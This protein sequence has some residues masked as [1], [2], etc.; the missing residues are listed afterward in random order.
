[1]KALHQ[2]VFGFRVKPAEREMI[3]QL[4]RHLQRT[5]GDAIRYLLR[6]AVR[7][8]NAEAERPQETEHD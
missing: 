8:L 1:M 2:S 3:R 4:A 5:E 7:S 6:S